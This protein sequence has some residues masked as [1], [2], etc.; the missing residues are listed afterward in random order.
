MRQCEEVSLYVWHS[1]VPASQLHPEMHDFGLGVEKSEIKKKKTK[2][3]LKECGGREE[4][5][6]FAPFFAPDCV[7]AC[8]HS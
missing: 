8:S 7:R 3:K 5:D 1:G 2:K 6:Y 4:N